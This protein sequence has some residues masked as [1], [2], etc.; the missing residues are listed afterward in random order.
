M[1]DAKLPDAVPC[2][3]D[4]AW[5]GACRRPS[6]NGWCTKHENMACLVCGTQ[7]VRSCEYTG[8][9]PLTC[10]MALCASCRHEPYIPGEVR[11]PRK[12]FNGEEYML[13]LARAK[14]S[15]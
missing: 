10:G 1:A 13:A 6:T 8:S 4:I 14:A 2:R 12:H 5:R 7:A 15:R 11:F 3:F 9:H